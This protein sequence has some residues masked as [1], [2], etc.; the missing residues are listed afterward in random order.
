MDFEIAKFFANMGHGTILD[1]ISNIIS[2]RT[3]LLAI[4]IVVIGVVMRRCKAK[5]KIV[6]ASFILSAVLFYAVS[7]LGFKNLGPDI[8]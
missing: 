5:R 4:W 1:L 8:R 6:L 3:F 7:E 2:T